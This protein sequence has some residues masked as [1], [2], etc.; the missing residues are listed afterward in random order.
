VE[1]A[2]LGVEQSW[3]GRRWRSR[4]VDDRLALAHAQ[5]RGL[6]DIVGRLLAARGIT[7]EEAERFLVPTL[8]AWMPDP[9]TLRDMEKA[10]TRIVRAIRDGEKVAVF[11][12]YDVDGATSTALLARFFRHLG[13]P[14]R[15]Y[16]PDR[17][18]EGYG[19]NL[20][21]LLRLKGEGVRLVL[22]VDCG[23]TA[24][25]PLEG[26]AEAGLEVLV[27][28][29]HKAEPRLPRAVAVVNPNRLD[30]PAGGPLAGLAAVGVT[31]L[32]V[33]AV[34]RLLRET[35]W[36]GAQGVPVPDLMNWLDIVALGTVCD[37]VPLA[38]LNRAFVARGLAVMGR[39]G[40]PGIAALADVAGITEA[41]GTYHAGFIVGPRVNAGGRVGQA[42]LGSRILSTDDAYEAADLARRLND[43][44]AE[45]RE[46]EAGVLE[47]ALAMVQAD[48][49]PSP[50]LVLAAG[51]GWHP[52]VIGIV[53]A[54]L[55]ERFG[56]PACVVALDGDL[57]KAS[58]RSVRGVDLGAAVIA[59]RQAGLLTAGGGHAMA[60]GFS[61][62][63]GRLADL[64][65][66]LEQRIAAQLQ[67]TG[68][69]VPTLHLDGALT[70]RGANP[71]L[72]GHLEKLAPYG[73]GNAE[74]RFAVT[75][76]RV[77][78]ADVV[79]SNHVRCILTGQDGARLKAIA[80]RALDGDLGPALLN[81][82]GRPL[83]LAGCLRADRWNGQ[84]GVQL[85]IDDAAPAGG[86]P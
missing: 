68:P 80:F 48:P 83:H 22:T 75:D 44:N 72:L 35:G 50:H 66:F 8:K 57:G 74:P 17:L 18:A 40:N 9:H 51:Q 85:F 58:G 26:A 25:D 79:G 5:G 84:D 36:Y 76:V 45:R 73:T 81:S 53:A 63:A 54:R 47:E 34:N 67:E 12:D 86:S 16:I 55:K 20:P 27:V 64:R 71:E 19:P 52:G 56:R 24:F 59:A 37:V 38:G 11:G 78:R 42:D 30:E 32:L 23:V 61:V 82:G 65:G 6:P 41:M 49:T 28:D 2:F 21:A 43:F 33:V 10:A 70:A 62:P 15:V 69:L 39:R 60:A 29:H 4:P 3:T 31:F 7:L 1:T 46:I 14:L 13:R 77:V